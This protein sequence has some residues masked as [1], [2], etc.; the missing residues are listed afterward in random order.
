VD[1]FSRDF[2]IKPDRRQR[3]REIHDWTQYFHGK[4]GGG[5]AGNGDEKT[6]G[7]LCG[8][9]KAELFKEKRRRWGKGRE[10]R[11]LNSERKE[12]LTV[13]ERLGGVGG[14]NHSC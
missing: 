11:G 7:G 9:G 13:G 10:F 6:Q 4:V 3:Q 1:I 8:K 12:S 14:I 5:E 2:G